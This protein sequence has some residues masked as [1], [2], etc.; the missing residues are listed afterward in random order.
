[1]KISSFV[2]LYNERQQS[3]LEY[4]EVPPCEFDI[5][6]NICNFNKLMSIEIDELGPQILMSLNFF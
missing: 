4:E 2:S 3:K 6:E 5:E 1:M